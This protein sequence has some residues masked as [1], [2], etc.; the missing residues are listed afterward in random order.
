MRIAPLTPLL[1]FAVLTALVAPTLFQGS[2]PSAAE[3]LACPPNPSPPD[4]AAPSIVIERPLQNQRVTG[5]VRIS[6][7]ASVF[8]ANVRISIYDGA[9]R[10]I[11]DTFTTAEE[12]GPALAPFSAAIPFRVSDEQPGCI[13]VFEA[14]A[15]DSTPVNIVQV[16]VVLTATVAPPKTGS[17]GLTE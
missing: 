13:R 3:R 7:R 16:E 5:P 14:S 2:T 1:V 12:A 17:A 6:G 15:R 11:V 9:G 4:P 8:E 10:I